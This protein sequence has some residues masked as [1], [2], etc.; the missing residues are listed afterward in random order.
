MELPYNVTNNEATI[1]NI[2]E[3][4]LKDRLAQEVQ[5]QLKDQLL[6]LQAANQAPVK[7][8]NQTILSSDRELLER[9]VRVEEELK[10]Q[11]ELLKAFMEQVD[12]RFEQMEKRFEQVEKRFEQVD[13]RFDQIDKRFN[14]MQWLIMSGIVITSVLISLL[15]FFPPSPPST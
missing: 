3:T 13:K 15:K 8:Q 2:V 9:M 4:L 5:R 6:A 11:R 12:K 1:E 7:P 14:F 10:H